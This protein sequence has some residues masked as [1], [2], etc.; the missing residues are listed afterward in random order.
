[1]LY[2]SRYGELLALAVAHDEAVVRVPGA[3]GPREEGVAQGLQQRLG[4]VEEGLPTSA[5]KTKI[6]L[7]S[8]PLRSGNLSTEI[9]PK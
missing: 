5:L 3:A 6:L 4:P 2:V 1:M 8:N 7:E 9:W